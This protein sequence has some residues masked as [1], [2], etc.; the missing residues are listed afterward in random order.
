M[1]HLSSIPFEIQCHNLDNCILL[2]KLFWDLRQTFDFP[3]LL[4]LQTM[5]EKGRNT[6]HKNKRDPALLVLR[7]QINN[8]KC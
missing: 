4:V 6:I 2:Q 8:L 3:Y 7:P 5:N 1:L